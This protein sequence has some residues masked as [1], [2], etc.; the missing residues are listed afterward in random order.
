M[1]VLLFKLVFYS[2]VSLAQGIPPT[3]PPVA[4]A[5]PA[6]GGGGGLADWLISKKI[7]GGPPNTYHGCVLGPLAIGNA[8]INLKQR[9]SLKRTANQLK[10][11][12]ASSAGQGLAGAAKGAGVAEDYD[13]MRPYYTVG[14]DGE[15]Q[16]D[17]PAIDVPCTD[18]SPGCAITHNGEHLT[19]PS[20]ESMP[21]AD[22]NRNLPPETLN[23]RLAAVELAMSKNKDIIAEVQAA[24]L[25]LSSP[26]SASE[27]V[28]AAAPAFNFDP[29]GRLQGSDTGSSA[30][31]AGSSAPLSSGAASGGFGLE[32][33]DNTP[34]LTA[35][36]DGL[37]SESDGAGAFAGGSGFS[38]GDSDGGVFGGPRRGGSGS[39]DGAAAFSGF[40]LKSSAGG[41]AGDNTPPLS[42]GNDRI[43]SAATNIFGAVRQR[44]SAFRTEGRFIPP[45]SAGAVVR[46]VLPSS[47]APGGPSSGG[48][49]AE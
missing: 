37:Y 35:L 40:R 47:S 36:P 11:V 27:T 28:A 44:Y 8:I 43:A 38:D 34:A 12:A 1:T 15:L 19:M 26:S 6:A 20:G 30:S 29:L 41:G 39:G 23:E 16:W 5:A 9:S 3:G 32:T 13:P 25:K 7:I 18:G 31:F 4:V 49:G 17:I 14:S 46:P 33:G 21:L 48:G 10:G 24:Q 42:F 45:S 2:V 22:I